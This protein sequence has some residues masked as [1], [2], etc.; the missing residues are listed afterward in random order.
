VLL[1]ILVNKGHRAFK[2]CRAFRVSKEKPDLKA[3]KAF[4]AFKGSKGKLDPKVTK[5]I[6]ATLEQQV[7]V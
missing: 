3:N 5:A 6:K 1:V 4:R 2:E 7:L